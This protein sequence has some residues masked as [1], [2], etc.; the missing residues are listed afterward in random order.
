MSL[1]GENTTEVRTG[2]ILKGLYDLTASSVAPSLLLDSFM[3]GI[4]CASAP[5]GS[6]VLWAKS[7][8]VGRILPITMICQQ[9]PLGIP[10][11]QV[12]FAIDPFTI[13]SIDGLPNITAWRDVL[14]L[15]TETAL[16]GFSSVLFMLT[17][18]IILRQS[19]SLWRNGLKVFIPI[20]TMIM[21]MLSLAHWIVSLTN[22]VMDASRSAIDSTRSLVSSNTHW[23][24]S[25]VVARIID[26]LNPDEITPA[27]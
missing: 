18:R 12:P 15:V 2:E 7:H 14:P 19:P 27:L 26:K 9:N 13:A 22:L 16:M 25:P 8:S 4:A 17:A 5:L 10:L 24:H 1:L 6:Y 21:Y 20:A 11:T 23:G 3:L